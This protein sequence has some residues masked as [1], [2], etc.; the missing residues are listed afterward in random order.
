MTVF[1]RGL[2]VLDVLRDLDDVF[3]PCNVEQRVALMDDRKLGP[4]D[5]QPGMLCATVVSASPKGSAI[6]PIGSPRSTQ[7]PSGFALRNI[8][9][10]GARTH[11]VER[12][13]NGSLAARRLRDGE[14]MPSA[15]MTFTIPCT[16][17]GSQ[18][19]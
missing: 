16:L 6:F 10:S 2:K 7:A 9:L 1:V 12:A 14:S 8:P 15:R 13:T 4:P 19:R 11:A 17:D 5:D 18:L 3:E